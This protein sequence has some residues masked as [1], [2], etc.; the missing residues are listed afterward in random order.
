MTEMASFARA[1]NN[2]YYIGIVIGLS[3]ILKKLVRKPLL[4]IKRE[5]IPSLKKRGQGRFGRALSGQLCT[6]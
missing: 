3:I 6:Y 1:S 5:D 4:P 2:N